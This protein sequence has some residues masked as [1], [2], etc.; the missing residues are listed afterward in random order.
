MIHFPILA[1]TFLANIIISNLLHFLEYSFD[2]P[3]LYFVVFLC[4]FW[5][6]NPT[7][8]PSEELALCNGPLK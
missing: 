4:L 3:S 7:L 5:M 1:P 8:V 2:L 6:H